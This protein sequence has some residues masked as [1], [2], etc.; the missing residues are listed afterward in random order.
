M[1]YTTSGH[2]LLRSVVGG[3]RGPSVFPTTDSL[4]R[5]GGA[6]FRNPQNEKSLANQG[7]DFVLVNNGDVYGGVKEGLPPS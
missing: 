3:D 6:S 7:P 5:H 4:S 1:R 2:V